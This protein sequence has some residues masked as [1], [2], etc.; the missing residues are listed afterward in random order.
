M[1]E[2]STGKGPLAALHCPLRP[3]PQ[4]LQHPPLPPSLPHLLRPLNTGPPQEAGDRAG[5]LVRGPWHGGRRND[6]GR[7]ARAGRLGAGP[8]HLEQERGRPAA[9]HHARIRR[10]LDDGGWQAGLWK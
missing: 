9:G 8:R 10:Q 1:S 3:A 2:Q 4:T 6:A 7:A 5:R